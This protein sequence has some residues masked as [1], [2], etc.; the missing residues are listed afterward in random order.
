[1]SGYT[2]LAAAAQVIYEGLTFCDT[3]SGLPA[4][5]EAPKWTDLSEQD[6]AQWVRL[7]RDAFLPD[8]LD[9]VAIEAAMESPA[10][11]NDRVTLTPAPDTVAAARSALYA[12]IQGGARPGERISLVELRLGYGGPNPIEAPD[13]VKKIRSV[14][15]HGET[16]KVR[17]DRESLSFELKS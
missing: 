12:W 3:L 4:N 8:Q 16:R 14:G 9:D 10:N 1:M 11:G 5:W 7:V 6:R 17:F 15:V 2:T 13:T